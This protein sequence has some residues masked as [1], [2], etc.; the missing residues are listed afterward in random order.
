MSAF[1]DKYIVSLVRIFRPIQNYEIFTV[2]ESQLYKYVQQQID[3]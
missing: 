1:S 3:F 2:N